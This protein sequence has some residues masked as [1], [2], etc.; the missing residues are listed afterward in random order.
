M[1]GIGTK[2]RSLCEEAPRSSEAGRGQ[3][4]FGS[5]SVPHHAPHRKRVARSVG[6][7]LSLP[8]SRPAPQQKAA[9]GGLVGGNHPAGPLS[10]SNDSQLGFAQRIT[11]I[12]QT[13]RALALRVG[14]LP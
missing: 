7:V 13:L 12:I 3:R 14:L 10:N 11:R 5:A 2:V 8:R 4:G 6:P 9:T 1:R